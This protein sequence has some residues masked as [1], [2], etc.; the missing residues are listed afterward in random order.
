MRNMPVWF[1]RVMF[2]FEGFANLTIA[3]DKYRGIKSVCL[4]L[5]VAEKIGPEKRRQYG[6]CIFSHNLD[7]KCAFAHTL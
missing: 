1:V 3:I 6:R 2:L 5:C 4:L 7:R